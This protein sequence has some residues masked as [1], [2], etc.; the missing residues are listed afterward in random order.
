MSS[1][2]LYDL[3]III[4]EKNMIVKLKACLKIKHIG[5]CNKQLHKCMNVRTSVI[6]FSYISIKAKLSK[7]GVKIYELCDGCSK[8]KGS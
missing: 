4:R 5:E 3:F 2:L 7:R 1:P 6:I 8:K